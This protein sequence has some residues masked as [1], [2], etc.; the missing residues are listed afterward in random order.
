MDARESEEERDGKRPSL[1]AVYE[2]A[3]L[4]QYYFAT[5]GYG[6]L[7]VTDLLSLDNA[8]FA[9]FAASIGMKSGHRMRLRRVLVEVRELL[10]TDIPRLK[11]Q[12]KSILQQ[13][14]DLGV[15]FEEFR[16]AALSTAAQV[17]SG[18]FTKH[19]ANQRLLR[20][21]IKE[22]F[23]IHSKQSMRDLSE[24]DVD[25]LLWIRQL[26]TSR[27]QQR[28]AKQ[29]LPYSSEGNLGFGQHLLDV[30][31][32]V[33]AMPCLWTLHGEARP[34][35]GFMSRAKAREL[36]ST[37]PRGNFILRLSNSQP[38]KIALGW[39]GKRNVKH[40][41]LCPFLSVEAF[42]KYLK[43]NSASLSHVAPACPGAEEAAAQGCPVSRLLAILGDHDY[44]RAVK[45]GHDELMVQY[46]KSKQQTN[47][48]VMENY[49]DFRGGA[50]EGADGKAAP[51]LKEHITGQSPPTP[52]CEPRDKTSADARRLPQRM[53]VSNAE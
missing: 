23:K 33:A 51:T 46:S 44:R 10:P 22:R 50:E 1:R 35:L 25:T 3:K 17:V 48:K 41:I 19:Q 20:H 18:F 42:A 28:D 52:P 2:E 13:L 31:R 12:T 47:V 7:T 5:R 9:I 8:E 32:T 27:K 4:E 39:R 11:R 14:V 16:L 49:S 38:D 21:Y 53:P 6:L 37:R 24:A 34:F 15:P 45:A 40:Q 43:E 29:P 26:Y 30:E 36:L